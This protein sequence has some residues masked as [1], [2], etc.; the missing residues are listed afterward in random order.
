MSNKRKLV[1]LSDEEEEEL[2]DNVTKPKDH[3]QQSFISSKIID[4]FHE[5]FINRNKYVE[6]IFEKE[7]SDIDK[8][9]EL[10]T[11]NVED[12]KEQEIIDLTLDDDNATSECP[13]VP[14]PTVSKVKRRPT[15]TDKTVQNLIK[16]IQDIDYSFKLS[17]SEV[18]CN[19][20]KEIS[21]EEYLNS[22]PIRVKVKRL[23]K[24]E[25]FTMM[26]TQPLSVILDDISSKFNI[27]VPKII[28]YL[29]DNIIDAKSTPNSLALT[30]ADIFE[31]LCR[32][33]PDTD[34]TQATDPSSK[35][36]DPN[37]I[38]LHLRDKSKKRTTLTINRFETIQQLAQIYANQ[39]NICVDDVILIFDDD[40]MSMDKKIDFYELE[41][42]D[43]IDVT[44]KS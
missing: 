38:E 10:M 44:V 1:Y 41:N 6:E 13:L 9:I 29:N 17:S 14:P 42:E 8:E 20:V 28:L 37:F 11:S 21:Y 27:P 2:E 26:R 19:T 23:D 7:E 31:V 36:D 35:K 5:K 39:K 43:Q 34:P 15:K 33:E 16:Q 22:K 32:Y 12:K 4:H 30:A 40:I 18:E 3:A 25:Y 24:L